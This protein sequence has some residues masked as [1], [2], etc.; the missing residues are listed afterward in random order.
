MRPS[1]AKEPIGMS[2]EKQGVLRTPEFRAAFAWIARPQKALEDGKKDK[3]AITMLFPKGADLSALK[4]AAAKVR[5]DKWG[6]DPK[7]WPKGLKSPF[8]DQGD[9][10]DYEGFEAGCT[11]ITATSIQKPGVVGPKPGPDGK[12]LPIENEA[13]YSGCYCRA[14]V[15]AF[16]YDKG[17]NKGVSFG[18]NNLQFLREGD[19]LGGGRAKAENDFDAVDTGEDPFAKD[20]DLPASDSVGAKPAAAARSEWD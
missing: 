11:F 17:V 5:D 4:A 10:S 12:P 16:W 13:V 15:N 8:K 1:I 2:D 3:Y 9:K 14:T 20:D 6:P 19:P 7:R 18:L